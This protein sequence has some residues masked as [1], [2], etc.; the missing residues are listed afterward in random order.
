MVSQKLGRHNIL[1]QEK[2]SSRVQS[3]KK[4]T[5]GEVLVSR[6]RRGMY[7]FREKMF[8]GFVRLQ[9]EANG[10]TLSGEAIENRESESARAPVSVRTGYHASKIPPGVKFTR[11]TDKK[12]NPLD[13]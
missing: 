7:T 1:N 11:E 8:R 6:T 12:P 13:K 5:Y 9:A 3:L 4:E 2:F 10:I